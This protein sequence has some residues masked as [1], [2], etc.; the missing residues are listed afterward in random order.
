MLTA[1]LTNVK[2]ECLALG[3]PFDEN[4]YVTGGADGS[5]MQPHYL[6]HRWRIAADALELITVNTP[7]I[8]RPAPY[9]RNGSGYGR[10]G[11]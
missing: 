11:H 10:R 5:F 7:N 4:M 1:R 8:P 3:V 9:V 6:S 2:A